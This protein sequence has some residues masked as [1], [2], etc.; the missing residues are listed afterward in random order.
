M[1]I[2]KKYVQIVSELT[3]IAKKRT[4]EERYTALGFTSNLDLLCDFSTEKLSSLLEQYLPNGKLEEMKAAKLITCIEELLE[5]M[6]FFCRSGIGG[7]VDITGTEVM[8]DTFRWTNG[9]GGTGVQAAMALQRIGC[10]SLVHLTDD[11]GEVCKLLDLPGIYVA[12]SEGKLIGTK[13]VKQTQ[14]QEV[15]AIVQFRKGDVIRLGEQEVTIPTSN[16]LILTKITVNETVPFYKPFFDYIADEGRH[17]SSY[18]LSSFNCLQQKKV[19]ADRLQKAKE[20]IMAYH[21]ANPA[22][23]VFFEDAHY[24]NKEIREMCMNQLYPEVDIVSLNEEELA[25]T[26]ES[27]G[28]ELDLEDAESLVRGIEALRKKFSMKKGMI[29]HTKDFSAYIGERLDTDIEAG[30]ICGNLL[31]TAK[32]MN[33][34]YGTMEQ[35][36]A[37]LQYPLSEKGM[38]F[39]KRAAEASW[40]QDVIIVPTRYVDRP[41]YTIGLGDS[42]VAGVQMCF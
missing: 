42:F 10:P 11:S 21:R 15:H 18:V 39:R 16:R 3:D 27:Y 36:E 41:P 19:L 5:T 1:S 32:A 2:E 6:V 4:R 35:I 30:L 17:V 40:G 28:M 26:L 9:M 33:G 13:A 29:V 34:W 7:E 24:H 12:S 22:G 23:V 25:Y 14:E 31:A 20:S 8:K 38:A 37:L